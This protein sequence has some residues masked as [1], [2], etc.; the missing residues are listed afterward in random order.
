MW[1]VVDCAP[2]AAIYYGFSR[3][4]T[5]EEFLCRAKD[6]SICE[7]LNRIP[8]KRGDVF[9]IMPGT[10]HAIGA[11]VLAVEV[12]QNS[13]TTFRIYDYSRR[14]CDG[15]FRPLHLERASRVLN[16][17]PVIPDEH[18]I[19]SMVSFPAFT[20][21]ELFSCP[22]FKVYKLDVRTE[23]NLHCDGESFHHLLCVGGCGEIIKNGTAYSFRRGE[24]FFLPAAMG[25]YSIRGTCR[26]LLSR[27]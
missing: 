11:G 27:V 16:Y 12:Q 24:S 3:H 10:I 7:T 18:K 22:Y 14:D 8:I 20:M 5:R 2:Q 21:T 26:V 13:I 6:G 15:Q 23:S 19:N 9:C 25:D 17:E 1:Y 4:M